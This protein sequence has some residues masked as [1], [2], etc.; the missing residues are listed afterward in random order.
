LGLRELKKNIQFYGTMDMRNF[1]RLICICGLLF[2]MSLT[3]ACQKRCG[4]CQT[5]ITEISASG[6]KV[7]TI[8]N[9]PVC[10]REYDKQNGKIVRETVGAKEPKTTRITETRCGEKR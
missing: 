6:T 10:G 3:T 9:V 8:P 7:D 2:V 4:I 1:V 5:T